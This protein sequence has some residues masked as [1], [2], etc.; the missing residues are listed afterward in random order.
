MLGQDAYPAVPP[1]LTPVLRRP[2]CAYHHTL[3]LRYGASPSVSHT[4]RRLAPGVSARPQ[5]S[6][7]SCFPYRVPSIGG[8][9]WKFCRT[10]S[11]FF[12]GLVQC[13]TAL[14]VCQSL[15]F[16]FSC[17][18]CAIFTPRAVKMRIPLDSHAPMWYHDCKAAMIPAH[19][20]PQGRGAYNQRPCRRR[21]HMAVIPCPRT[22]YHGHVIGK[23]KEAALCSR[24]I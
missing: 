5:K 3:T 6:I 4:P 16:F 19:L 23:K 7:R 9:L 1:G 22:W 21:R 2:L 20:A 15:F 11:L 10:Y 13:S 18:F 24:R 8:S 12:N 17:H 14:R